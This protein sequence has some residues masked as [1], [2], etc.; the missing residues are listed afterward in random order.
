[1]FA[2]AGAGLVLPHNAA[3]QEAMLPPVVPDAAHLAPGDLIFYDTPIDHVAI[4]VGGGM[5]V[6]AAH[7]GLPVRLVPIRTDNLVGAGRP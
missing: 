4:Y 2:W 3:A 5:M 6:E 7:A 1:M